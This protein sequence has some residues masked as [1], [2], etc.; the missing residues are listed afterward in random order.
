[1]TLKFDCSVDG[2][3]YIEVKNGGALWVNGSYIT[4][5]NDDFEYDWW[6]RSESK[7][8]IYN[9]TVEECGYWQAG[10]SY[11]IEI[12]SDN[13]KVDSCLIR[14]CEIGIYCYSSS[15]E[16]TNNF[17]SDSGRGIQCSEV[18]SPII[19]NNT[20]SGIT[21]YGIGC[22]SSSPEITNNLIS[23]NERGLECQGGSDPKIINNNI[24]GNSEY[25]IYCYSSSPEIIDNIIID[26]KRG[27]QCEDS[28]NPKI[29]NNN[30]ITGNSEYGIYCFS[31]SPEIIDNIIID[32]KRGI[33]CEDS[34]NPKIINNT[35]SSNTIIGIACLSS[36]LDIIDNVLL[37]NEHG[38]ECLNSY[39]LMI[40]NNT[41]SGGGEVGILC[42][43]S[44]SDII[45]NIITDSEWG[46]Y[47]QYNS[48]DC[49][50]DHNSICN[51]SISGIACKSSSPIISENNISNN[52]AGIK[53][54][55]FLCPEIINNN[56]SNNIKQGITCYS[57]MPFIVRNIISENEMGIQCDQSSNTTITN[58]TIL[59]NK[60]TGILSSYSALII[61]NNTIKENKRG[62]GCQDSSDST[63]INNSISHNDGEGIICFSSSPDIIG[64]IISENN[65]SVCCQGGSH[66]IIM[67]NNISNDNQ[68]GILCKLLSSPNIVRNVISGNKRGVN[69][70]EGS[71]PIIDN[72]T[73][74][75]NKHL[76]IFCSVSSSPN[77]IS[78]M[79]SGSQYG[80]IC[81]SSSPIIVNSTIKDTFQ[82][83]LFI[84]TNSHP[85]LINTSMDDMKIGINDNMSS[86]TF[87]WFL[88]L[89][90]VFNDGSPAQNAHLRINDEF[91]ESIHSAYADYNGSASLINCTYCVKRYDP[92]EGEII[93]EYHYFNVSA[94]V[95]NHVVYKEHFALNKNTEITLIIPNAH[96]KGL[97][98]SPCNIS[99]FLTSDQI[100]FDA[101]SIID[102]D[103]ILNFTFFSH[104]DG[105]LYS[106][107]NSIFYTRLSQGLH[108]ISLSV[109]DGFGG[110]L[111]S[112]T[113]ITVFEPTEEEIDFGPDICY[114]EY[115]F[116]G[117]GNLNITSVS[118][119][120]SIPKN[121]VGNI[122]RLKQHG[123][124][125]FD[126][127]QIDYSYD[128]VDINKYD[129]DSIILNYKD[130]SVDEWFPCGNVE[131]DAEKN[132]ITF[133]N[134][135]NYSKVLVNDT[136][137]SR[138]TGRKEYSPR[139]GIPLDILINY[140]E[141]ELCIT[142]D[143][144]GN[145]PIAVAECEKDIVKIDTLV[146]FNAIVTYNNDDEDL[147][148]DL[149]YWWDIDET[150]DEDD[151]GNRLDDEDLTGVVASYK[152]QTAGSHLVTL[153]VSDG[154]FTS[155]DSLYVFVMD[156]HPPIAVAGPDMV[157]RIGDNVEFNASESYDLDGDTLKFSWD[158]G[159]GCNGDGKVE[160]HRY[161]RIGRFHVNLTVS[162][163]LNNT[164]DTLII[165]VEKN[166]IAEPKKVTKSD[167][168][169]ERGLFLNAVVVLLLCL[170]L[171]ILP[172]K[173][174]FTQNYGKIKMFFPI[175]LLLLS[176]FNICLESITVDE[177]MGAHYRTE[178]IIV[179]SGW[180]ED[181]SNDI[182]VLDENITVVSGGHLLLDNTFL[183]FKCNYAGEYGIVVEG[184]GTLDIIN[185]STITSFYTEYNYFLKYKQG[186][187]GR[188]EESI[189]ERCGGNTASGLVVYSNNLY[190]THCELR[191]NTIGIKC[192]ESS[193]KILFNQIYGCEYGI[194]IKGSNNICKPT[195]INNTISE[196]HFG[197]HVDG[198]FAKPVL[199]NNIITSQIG[200]QFGIECYGA[201]SPIFSNDAITSNPN[202]IKCTFAHPT[203]INCTITNSKYEDFNLSVQSDVTLINTTFDE[204]KCSILSGSTLSA[205]NYLDA[206]C[207]DVYGEPLPHT[208]IRI[209]D[210]HTKEVKTFITDEAGKIPQ[211]NCTYKVIH[212]DNLAELYNATI[213]AQHQRTGVT[214]E[215][216]LLVKRNDR[217]EIVLSQSNNPLPAIQMNEDDSILF[218]W[219]LDDY[220]FDIKYS[221]DQI[222][223]SYSDNEHIKVTI[224]PNHTVTFTP[225]SNWSGTENITFTAVN[226]DGHS[227][228][229]TGSVIVG[230]VN[231]PPVIRLPDVRGKENE[232]ITM[233]LNA[234]D[235]DGDDITFRLEKKYM[236]NPRISA[237]QNGTNFTIIWQSDFEDAGNHTI[238]LTAADD[239][240]TIP[241]H[242][243]VDIENVNRLPPAYI[244]CLDYD[245]KEGI[246]QGDTI[247]F[248][249]YI[250]NDMES[251]F[252]PDKDNITY[253]WDYGDNTKL[254]NRSV[255]TH[256]YDTA[257]EFT[258]SL[259]AYD[260]TDYNSTTFDI[261][262]R[263]L[264]LSL[265][266]DIS[267]E[268]L[269]GVATLELNVSG[270][271]EFVE[272]FI[273]LTSLG[274]T[275]RGPT[276][277]IDLDTSSYPNGNYTV[278]VEV[279]Y[280][281]EKDTVRYL[282]KELKISNPNKESSLFEE[283]EDV[284]PVTAV[285]GIFVLGLLV[286]YARKG[287][288]LKPMLKRGV[289]K[290]GRLLKKGKKSKS[291]GEPLEDVHKE[292]ETAGIV[293]VEENIELTES[294]VEDG[295][296]DIIR[297]AIGK[298]R[299][300]GARIDKKRKQFHEEH[301]PIDLPSTE[302]IGR[303][304]HHI[305]SKSTLLLMFLTTFVVGT[306]FSIESACGGGFIIDLDLDELLRII[307]F[308]LVGTLLIVMFRIFIEG[309]LIKMYDLTVRYK[310]WWW[311]NIVILLSA[312]IFMEPYGIPVQK[313]YEG[314]DSLSKKRFGII[315]IT[316]TLSI[317]FFL[318]PCYYMM[319]YADEGSIIWNLGNIQSIILFMLIAYHLF[320]FRPFDGHGIYKW[321]RGVWAVLFVPSIGL[322][323]L[324]SFGVLPIGFIALSGCIGLILFEISLLWLYKRRSDPKEF[325]KAEAAVVEE[326][327]EEEGEDIGGGLD[328]NAEVSS[329][330]AELSEV[331]NIPI[332]KKDE[333][334][335]V[336]VDGGKTEMPDIRDDLKSMQEGC[337]K[338]N[339]KELTEPSTIEKL[340]APKKPLPP[341]P[342]CIQ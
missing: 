257:G 260:G 164:I 120:D 325:K 315:S 136:L 242:M 131:I 11:G 258:V 89:N 81:D 334:N 304:T 62:I 181:W 132:E 90:V 309:I 40:N 79:I 135:Y 269:N 157:V 273:G 25:G 106:G 121:I 221:H 280:N 12:S 250:E 71:N 56:I 179:D 261:L 115:S 3:Y 200:K 29:I 43:S 169:W 154:F 37:E 95:Q 138:I 109:T 59:N 101:T 220:F 47:C 180:N 38:I 167:I 229:G 231:D 306:A 51:N 31:S 2:E 319:A 22:L 176:L 278:V 125:V 156:N 203:F 24:T 254:G 291:K 297:G 55:G 311:G 193:P 321:N 285:T 19:I 64:N 204:S 308:V 141:V 116:G 214:S 305:F 166:E 331:E 147:Q 118:K 33:Q 252:D 240:S 151:N 197:I 225:D 144:I 165:N 236:N 32:N 312:L 262:V 15:P 287:D 1:V 299:D 18:S 263:A 8:K 102:D 21:N 53:T 339:N 145:P 69:C 34:L 127:L 16:I 271:I 128:N 143:V 194:V 238:N 168:P 155:M 17:V 77:I 76:G 320:P 63:I 294:A 310:V 28:L 108:D 7:G 35:I 65:G 30:N 241:L 42:D 173:L 326:E 212:D 293:V 149:H 276:Y 282:M 289:K 70:E 174:L 233:V 300:A 58:N 175:I 222:N 192:F 227:M 268:S 39:T 208:N 82:F 124:M 256:Q 328:G 172:I 292:N 301:G 219:N 307:P 13:V 60:M 265:L 84:D 255:V 50:I 107:F 158:F 171:I 224:N 160:H 270:D 178:G 113:N 201:S 251:S 48:S 198:L 274:R 190:I 36:S 46:V 313:R 210:G 202:G 85:I 317:S 91:G 186:S 205:K 232:T 336:D 99:Y 153:C 211:V 189:I 266:T 330:R 45:N 314:V 303:V 80:I 338:D 239:V 215:K 284:A 23:G 335:N 134:L 49:L 98:S 86:I 146:K 97:V 94:T 87:Q 123:T 279:H 129:P 6:F 139:R 140:G 264:D 213:K 137:L 195:L 5:V 184:G 61:I 92:V 20:I 196:N 316:Q 246:V 337:E 248:L 259:T 182:V 302:N 4:A 247:V 332:T 267:N 14:D 75:L 329:Q 333:L 103:D 27:I 295:Q 296:D 52:L 223:Y 112:F 318:I 217:V 341:P 216:S 340:P 26:N 78:S 93:T 54:D 188:L 249:S 104:S 298:L 283:A 272:Y 237:Q 41:I 245:C 163:D 187:T 88:D 133:I 150:I 57:S 290:R 281:D 228:N 234:T 322:F 111:T 159:D 244:S 100:I 122:I 110:I 226:P 44:S 185:N 161:R 105:K 286:R 83:D 323:F 277:P 67:N 207:R 66:P 148:K 130:T 170:G 177:V 243:N 218:A 324:N 288:I 253:T 10:K 206:S 209:K 72:N 126:S 191:N 142:A 9:S 230:P 68:V 96:P 199:S 342:P 183:K 119:C 327:K 117:D 162:D 275:T 73:I 235:I 74:N 114:C 152:F